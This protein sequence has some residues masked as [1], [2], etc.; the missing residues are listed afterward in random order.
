MPAGAEGPADQAG[1]SLAVGA[2]L[3]RSTDTTRDVV[4]VGTASAPASIGGAWTSQGPARVTGGQVEGIANSPVI[5]AVQAI[6]A[7]PTDPAVL[8]IGAVNGGIW[9]TTNALDIGPTWVP[10]TDGHASLSIGA[11]AL[12]PTDSTHQTLVAGVGRF[13][14]FGSATG[15]PRSG[16][17]RTT[18]G[19]ASWAVLGEGTLSGR[20]ISGIVGRGPTIVAAVNVADNFTCVDIGIYRSSNTGASFTRTSTSN[21]LITGLPLGRAFDLAGDPTSGGVLYTAIRDTSTCYPGLEANGVYRSADTGATWTRV[22][23]ATMNAIMANPGVSNVR[24]AV[25]NAGEVYAGIVVAGQLAGLF[26]SGNSGATWS[27]LDTPTT[28]ENGSIMGLQP[29][30]KAGSQGSIHFSIAADPVD[31]SIV[32]VGG[33]RQPGNGDGL[34][35]FPNSIGASDYSGRLFRVDSSLAPGSQAV[36]LTHGPSTVSNSAPHADSRRI[37]F[38]AAGRLLE[39]DDG[40]VYYRTNP[41]G[42]GDWGGLMGDVRV[43]EMHDVAYDRVSGI[44]VGG[45]QDTGTV[46]QTAVGG[47]VWRSV[48]TADGGDVQIDDSTSSS[49]SRR[50][51]SFQF[52]QS[53]RRRIVNASGVT[54]STA[55]PART[56]IGGGPAFSAQFVTPIELNAVDPARILFAGSNDLYES[57][58][59]GDTIAA[60]GLGVAVSAIAYGG[61]SAGADNTAV[62]YALGSGTNSV[63]VRTA[64]SGPPV[65]TT[66]SPGVNPLRDVAI[67]PSDWRR[68]WVVSSANEVFSTVD[69]GATWTAVTG[70]L[71]SQT[72]ELRSVVYMPGASGAVV[73]GGLAA[74]GPCVESG[75][76][77]RMAAGSPGVWERLGTGLP[78]APV[79]DMEHDAMDDILV[80]S[81]MGRGAWSLAA[82]SVVPPTLSIDDVTLAEGDV[83]TTIAAFTATLSHASA[84]TVTVDFSTSDGSASSGDYVAVSGTLTFA[85]GETAQPLN[86]EVIGDV[87]PEPDETFF[88]NLASPVNATLLD[89]QGA[90]TISNDDLPALSIADVAVTEGAGGTVGAIFNVILS[91]PSTQVVSV[92]FATMDVSAT[93]ADGDY[94]PASGSLVLAPGTTSQTLTVT[95]NGDEDIESDEVFLVALSSP[96]NATIAAGQ[97]RGTIVSDEAQASRVFVSVSGSD[98]NDCRDSPTPCRTFAEGVSQVAHGGE[99]IVLETGSYGGITIFKSVAINAPRG[100]TAFAATAFRVNAESGDVVVLRGLTIKSLVPGSGTGVEFLSGGALFLEESIV[101]GWAHGVDFVGGDQLHVTGTTVRNSELTGLRAASGPGTLVA[102]D[103]SR[104]LGTSAGCG[105]EA[106]DDAAVS[107]TASV[108]A[109][110]AAGFCASG[111]QLSVGTSIAAHNSGAG[112][113]VTSGTLRLRRLLVTGN[114]TGLENDGGVL[115]SLGNSLVRGN[116]ADSAG[117]ITPVAGR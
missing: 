42:T 91:A 44:T 22:S 21:G 111:G 19:G 109:G 60:L 31:E 59:R 116:E 72:A 57:F 99:V 58:D 12:D 82:A 110:N 27:S 69:A 117:T 18:D 87:V 8:W 35:T 67:D 70:N 46:E 74:C 13:S 55:F 56:V 33:D 50:Y 93:V 78:N 90:G 5:G 53:F 73:V 47:T 62:I 6:V 77:F 113:R 66:S 30:R 1:L 38:D 37:A 2:D 10:L 24:L 15:G 34:A 51:S 105:V 26:R 112:L 71:A 20:N 63:Y 17:L 115:E 103:R 80:V 65:Q 4:P 76:V 86:V 39:V 28:N 84:Q 75:G 68:A 104:F 14:S 45:N 79:W 98:A 102:I 29:S 11:L 23:D 61:R 3:S 25:G 64:G 108:A 95:V 40:G 96:T 16:V 48:H 81:T 85:P 36:A 92:S 54:T 52:L 9:K 94:V 97:A 114:G 101:D 89:G 100:V 88:V 107:V 43:T 49:Q 83:G 7:H 41:R 32:Y 106:L